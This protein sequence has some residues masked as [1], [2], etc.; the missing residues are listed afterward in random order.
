VTTDLRFVVVDEPGPLD[1]CSNMDW[2]CVPTWKPNEGTKNKQVP[3]SGSGRS[4]AT[5]P[6]Y[7]RSLPVSC[8]VDRSKGADNQ[9]ASVPLQADAGPAKIQKK[10]TRHQRAAPPSRQGPPQIRGVAALFGL[11]QKPADAHHLRFTQPRAMGRKVS[12]EFIRR[13]RMR[14]SM[15]VVDE[16]RVKQWFANPTYSS[17]FSVGLLRIMIG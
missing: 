9:A 11:R 13:N 17:H 7:E 6:K 4:L 10:R 15:S 16:A 12:D 2:I 8:N 1:L 14:D 3:E 5:I